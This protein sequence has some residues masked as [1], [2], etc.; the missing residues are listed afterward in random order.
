MAS[1]P[2]M[3]AANVMVR[4]REAIVMD[5]LKRANGENQ[6]PA[7]EEELDQIMRAMVCALSDDQEGFDQDLIRIW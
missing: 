3:E 6:V 1:S 2:S 7:T 5:A 4:N